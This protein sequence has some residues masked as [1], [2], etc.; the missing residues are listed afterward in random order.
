MIQAGSGECNCGGKL[1]QGLSVKPTKGNAVLFWSMVSAV[2]LL[3]MDAIHVNYEIGTTISIIVL[4]LLC[5]FKIVPLGPR[6][7]ICIFD[8][9]QVLVS[10]LKSP[11]YQ[12][13]NYYKRKLP[14]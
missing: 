12:I 1:V 13:T 7:R 8:H 14:N 5:V 3:I 11:W 6:D 2:N 10:L 9:L 4:V